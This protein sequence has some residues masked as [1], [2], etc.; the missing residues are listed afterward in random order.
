MQN[1]LTEVRDERELSK[2]WAESDLSYV[3]VVEDLVEL[4]VD[5]GVIGFDELPPLVQEKTRNRQE[6]RKTMARIL[7][8]DN[9]SFSF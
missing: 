6:A 9:E 3:R 2:V 5:K 7:A 1:P 8:E 4:L